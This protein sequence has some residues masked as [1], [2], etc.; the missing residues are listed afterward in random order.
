MKID[1]KTQNDIPV[2]N[3]DDF[4]NLDHCEEGRFPDDAE[5]VQNPV[6]DVRDDL[7]VLLS[8]VVHTLPQ[9][10]ACRCVFATKFQ[11]LLS[12]RLTSLGKMGAPPV[13]PL[14][15]SETIVF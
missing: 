6:R 4:V 15:P 10:I 12:E 11:H 14:N 1:R 2:E 8:E 7:L 5:V 3:L 13:P 9:R